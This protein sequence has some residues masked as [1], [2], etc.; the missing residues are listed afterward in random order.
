MTLLYI[1]WKKISDMY[2]PEAKALREIKD[3]VITCYEV[4]NPTKLSE[5]DAIVEK[6]KNK[7]VALFAR[8]KNK[9]PKIPQCG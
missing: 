5:V 8:L 4:A 1:F 2:Y 6:Y 3:R 9:Y 7:E